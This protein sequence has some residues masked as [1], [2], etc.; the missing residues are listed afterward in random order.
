MFPG[1]T[2]FHHELRRRS[3]GEESAGTQAGQTE[4]GALLQLHPSHTAHTVSHTHTHGYI[5]GQS[6]AQFM[7]TQA[8]V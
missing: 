5:T 7:G 8:A 2:K 1:A 3:R 4:G 6:S